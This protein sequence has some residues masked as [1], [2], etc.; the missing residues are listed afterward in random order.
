MNG[1]ASCAFI[2]CF[3][4]RWYNRVI[5]WT[6]PQCAC[7]LCVPVCLCICAIF[8]TLTQTD[9]RNLKCVNIIW[10]MLTLQNP[11]HFHCHLSVCVCVCL[12]VG[13]KW[14]DRAKKRDRKLFRSF[15]IIISLVIV[16]LAIYNGF[17][18]KH[19]NRTTSKRFYFLQIH[20]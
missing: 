15:I 19:L 9:P 6:L 13:R 5:Y 20:S 10:V 7:E 16:S 3:W 17:V 18:A 14:N 2:R 12:C 1:I 11:I 8:R 4:M